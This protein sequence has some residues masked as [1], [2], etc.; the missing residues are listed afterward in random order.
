M[1]FTHK[2]LYSFDIVE[3]MQVRNMTYDLCRSLLGE[4]NVAC[5]MARYIP[6][7]VFPELNLYENGSN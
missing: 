3:E 7:A 4:D 5:I 2:Y 6:W 1:V